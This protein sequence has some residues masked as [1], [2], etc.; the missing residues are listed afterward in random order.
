MKLSL[1][2]PLGSVFNDEVS[3]V[4]LPGS[5]GQFTVLPGHTFLVS[6]L[7]AGTLKLTKAG[8]EQSFQLG[9]GV[10]EIANDKITILV[11]KAS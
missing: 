2:T 6:E 7:S 5:K 11:E 10:A 4:T 3:S 9:N 8:K 1:I